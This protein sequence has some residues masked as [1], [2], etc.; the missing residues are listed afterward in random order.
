MALNDALLKTA[1]EVR[2]AGPDG[3][4]I[5]AGLPTDVAAGVRRVLTHHS[6]ALASYAIRQ[7]APRRS[8]RRTALPRAAHTG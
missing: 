4:T 6:G 5:L 1:L 8:L 3:K 2:R 7:Q